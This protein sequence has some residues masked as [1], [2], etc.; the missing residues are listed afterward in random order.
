MVCILKGLVC[1]LILS[2]FS[3]HFWHTNIHAT[4]RAHAHT[5]AHTHY[6]TQRVEFIHKLGE[7]PRLHVSTEDNSEFGYL[8]FHPPSGTMLLFCFQM[9]KKSKLSVR[10]ILIVETADYMATILPYTI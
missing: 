10:C 1:I 5:Y 7:I 9:A 3:Y 4:T 8:S 2:L 6:I